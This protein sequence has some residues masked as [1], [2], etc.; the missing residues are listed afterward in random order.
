MHR[1]NSQFIFNTSRTDERVVQLTRTDGQT[2]RTD[3]HDDNPDSEVMVAAKVIQAKRS[4]EMA[5][6]EFQAEVSIISQ[7]RHRNLM[8]LQG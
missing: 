3:G 6:R 4:L 7:I 8:Q 1:G 2:S 5:V